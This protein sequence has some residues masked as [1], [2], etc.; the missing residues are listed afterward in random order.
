VT[1]Q[2][3]TPTGGTITEGY[4]KSLFRI[5]A[6]FKGKHV[7]NWC[8]WSG[9]DIYVARNFCLIPPAPELGPAVK[10][11]A[12][13]K[14]WNGKVEYDRILWVDSDVTF[15]PADV[16]NI[17]GHDVDVC[18]G[19]VKRDFNV[20]A[21]KFYGKLDSGLSAMADVVEYARGEDGEAINGFDEFLKLRD[22]RGLVE[23]GGCGGAFLCI[24]RGVYEA[25]P[26]PWYRTRNLR[27][28]EKDEAG[29]DF[30]AAELDLTEDLGFSET[31]KE[32]GFRIWADP[33]V[34]PT[35]EK[36]IGLR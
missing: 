24:K 28:I 16:E 34:R 18:T 36:R 15:S 21:L 5:M 12:E 8:T 1:I 11:F 26:Y 3:C 22:E 27:Q 33:M 20:F 10:L 19:L 6:A 4:V 2:L 17:I 14:P 13:R 7:V 32:A 30:L 23:V 29:K 9:G 25:I 31:L 35:H